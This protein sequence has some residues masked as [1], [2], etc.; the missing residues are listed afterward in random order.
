VLQVADPG[1][2]VALALLGGMEFR[3][4]AQVAMAP[5]LLDFLDVLGALDLLN[6]SSSACKAAYPFFVIGIFTLIPRYAFV[7]TA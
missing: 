3:I 7:L 6:R 5:C 1:V 4:L 2:N